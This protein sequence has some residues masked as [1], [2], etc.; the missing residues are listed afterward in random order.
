MA[1]DLD[2]CNGCNA[3]VAACYAE[4]NIPVMGAEEMLLGRTMSWMRIERFTEHDT[5][6]GTDSVDS[7]FLPMLCQ[8]CDHAPCETVCPVY[9]TYHTEE[10]LNAQVYNRCVGTRYCANNCPYKVR[11]FN[12][13]DAQ[14]PE[15]LNLQL[16]PDVTG[17]SAGVMEKCTFCVQRIAGGKEKAR[18]EGRPVQDGDVTPACAQ[19]CPANAIEF[20]DLNDPNSRVSQ[21]SKDD[22][23][24]H[25]LG[26]FN[27]RP[28]VTYLKKVT[29][30]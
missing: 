5:A 16:N 19:T 28:A 26:V 12:W 6:Q 9:A 15:P 27:T 3:C 7:R 1:I 24:Y 18:D 14:F 8:H 11:R 23:G 17:R 2:T 20:G 13:S 21:L 30:S 10:G 25:A 29:Q 4:N 22:R